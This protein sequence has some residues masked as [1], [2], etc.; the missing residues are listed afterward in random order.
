MRLKYKYP[1]KYMCSNNIGRSGCKE[2]KICRGFR[3]LKW[4]P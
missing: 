3:C 2:Y 1:P 4:E